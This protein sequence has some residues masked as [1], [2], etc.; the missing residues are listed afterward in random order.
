MQRIADVVFPGRK[1]EL[2]KIARKITPAS[3]NHK[4]SPPLR[5]LVDEHTIIKKL[6]ARIP[7][8]TAS[9]D[10]SST[11]CTARLNGAIDFIRIYAD[12]FHHAK[13]EKILFGFFDPASDIIASFVTEHETGRAHVRAVADG[14]K[15]ADLPAIRDHLAAYGALLTEHIKKEDEILYPWMDQT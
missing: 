12:G 10:I 14:I 4:L 13:E 9:I 7:E 1:V 3:G 15:T 8:L 5:E 11:A 6:L 2:P